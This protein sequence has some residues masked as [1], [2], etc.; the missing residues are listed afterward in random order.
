M[1]DAR[2]LSQQAAMCVDDIVEIGSY[3]GRSTI[4]L[5]HGLQESGNTKNLVYAIESHQ[6]F[7]GIHGGEFG[8]ADRD[9]FYKNVTASG[10]V[11][12]IALVNLPSEN[13]ARAWDA[14]I[15]LL[16]IDGDHR[17]E[18]VALDARL[19]I[20]ALVHGGLVIFDDAR[21]SDDGPSR[22]IDELLKSGKFK[23]AKGTDKLRA[24]QKC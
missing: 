19:W 23:S 24:L 3:R 8:P 17:Y 22:V 7:V 20:P 5:A 14:K 13:A 21:H 15:G 16:F 11:Q 4:A 10:L 1:P 12:R 2:F 9:A 18:A 6:P